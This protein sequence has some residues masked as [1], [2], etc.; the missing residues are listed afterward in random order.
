MAASGHAPALPLGVH[1]MSVS[2]RT[3]RLRDPCPPGSATDRPLDGWWRHPVAGAAD[4]A[5]LSP[6][7]H[8]AHHFRKRAL[9][10][11]VESRPQP[12]NRCFVCGPENP[13]GLG[14][15][16]RLEDGACVSEF[17]PGENHVGYPGVVHG[18]IL[19]S[20]LDDVMANWLYLKGARAY[21]ARCD[22][23][24]K[25]AL[26]VGSTLRLEGRELRRKGRL[27]VME[28]RAIRVSDG[29]LVAESEG[30]FM[31]LDETEFL[32]P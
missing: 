18:G 28:G 31:V 9:T 7:R 22:I 3:R 12:V 8:P 17:T 1:T 11:S 6:F 2:P 20:A 29:A 26:D 24:F 4:P 32:D 13:I 16:F 10:V 19:F 21:T 15:A 5:T 27:V 14:L 23:R 25:T 30:A